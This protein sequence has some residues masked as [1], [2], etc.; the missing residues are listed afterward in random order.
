MRAAAALLLLAVPAHAQSCVNDAPCKGGTTLQQSLI[1]NPSFE[2][3][4]RCPTSYGHLTGYADTWKQATSATSDLYVRGGG[5]TGWDQDALGAADGVAY[6]GAIGVPSSPYIEYVGAC[7]STPL[8]ANTAYTLQV[9]VAA[10][11]IQGYG[12]DT[13][14]KSDLYCISS[15]SSCGTSSCSSSCFPLSGTVVNPGGDTLL[16][17]AEPA[18]GLIHGAGW[19]TMS[20]VFTPTVACHAVMLG[21]AAGATVESGKSGMMLYY[22]SLNLQSGGGWSGNTWDGCCVSGA[23]AQDTRAPTCV[24]TAA[25][26]VPTFAPV[27]TGG[28]QVSGDPFTSYGGKTTQFYLPLGVE[29]TLLT[30]PN[31]ELRGRTKHSGVPGDTQ[32]W[33]DHFTVLTGQAGH[34]NTV[35]VGLNAVSASGTASTAGDRVVAALQKFRTAAQLEVLNL[36]VDGVAAAGGAV[37]PQLA[38]GWKVEA[39]HIG[40]TE[41][42]ALAAGDVKVRLQSAIAAKFAAAEDKLQHM[43][44]DVEF[45]GLDAKACAG[46]FPEMWG[47]VPMSNSTERLLTP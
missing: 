41:V 1:P 39:K 40:H 9:S 44:I 23:C 26:A 30:C 3:F 29:H 10:G 7:L 37:L 11:L 38:G 47:V 33:F 45:D 28:M 22:D 35:T 20:F 36:A 34:Q 2:D 17:T 4:S 24:G 8:A 43:H 19:K 14:G 18:G 42:V 6:V 15:K 5:C 13:N 25:P 32:Q 46:V 12:G 27:S 21:P 31:V 16:A